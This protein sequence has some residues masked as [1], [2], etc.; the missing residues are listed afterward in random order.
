MLSQTDL[1][2]YQAVA[3]PA[4]RL[5]FRRLVSDITNNKNKQTKQEN[6]YR[7]DLKEDEKVHVNV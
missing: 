3:I 2:L 6:W 5:I 1:R 4:E 7:D